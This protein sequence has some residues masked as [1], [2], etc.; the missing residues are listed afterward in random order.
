[1]LELIILLP[2]SFTIPTI[3]AWKL[4]EKAG[5]KGWE[6]LVP[7]YNLYVFLKSIKKPMWWMALLFFPFLNVFMY[8]LMLVELVKCF[9][10][11]SLGEQFLSVVFPFIYLPYLGMKSDEVFIDPINIGGI[12]VDGGAQVR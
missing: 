12:P 5:R 8:M 1:M 4:F 6:T 2:L 11:F 7:F 10:K 3:F 9:N